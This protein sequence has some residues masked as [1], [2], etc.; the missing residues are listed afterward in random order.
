MVAQ[1][2]SHHVHLCSEF[3]REAHSGQLASILPPDLHCSYL[4]VPASRPIFSS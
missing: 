2:D 3:I 4:A 1:L